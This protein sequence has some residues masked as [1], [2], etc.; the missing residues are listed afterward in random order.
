[1]ANIFK[2]WFMIFFSRS[3]VPSHILEI[4]G[5]SYLEC[6]NFFGLM[7]LWIIDNTPRVEVT[8]SVDLGVGLVSFFKNEFQLGSLLLNM[9]RESESAASAARGRP[10]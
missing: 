7:N 6:K 1:M 10:L 9:Q 4:I 5:D 3:S 8:F 2:N